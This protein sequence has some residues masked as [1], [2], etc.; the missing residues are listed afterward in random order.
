MHHQPR[1]SRV[2]SAFLAAAL[3]SPLAAQTAPLLGHWEYVSLDSGPRHNPTPVEV[4]VWSDFVIL[5]EGIP[6]L[7]LHFE[8]A[9]LGKGSW[10]R[11]T[12][13]LDGDFM[14]MRQE[15]LEQWAFTSC[16]LNG[17]AVMLELFAG[18]NTQDNR[19]EITKVAAGDPNPAH[20]E[21][22]TICGGTDDRVPSTDARTGRI[23]PV[24]CTG[25]IID[26]PAAGTNKVHLSAGHCVATG[27]VLQ[28][29]VPSS[30]ANCTRQH[31][32]AAK[33]FAID[34]A[35][36]VFVNGG[37]GNDYWVFRC[38]PNSTTGRTTFEEQGAAWTLSPA[39]PALNTPLG[40]FGY[41]L[42]G[43]DT[44]GAP[45]AGSCSCSSSA[46]TGTRNQT[47]QYHFGP[48]IDAPGTSLRYQFDTCGGNS[49]SPVRDNTTGLAVAIH[50]HG[51]CSNPVGTTGNQGTQVTH[52]NLVAAIATVAGT[53]A[54]A[55][56][57]CAGA[58]ALI[59]GTN[60]PFHNLDSTL[61]TV[62]FPCGFNVGNDVWFRFTALFN[63]SHTFDTCTP[64]RTFDTV[65]QLF[66]G[67]CTSL[68][69]IACNDDSCGLGSSITATLAAGTTYYLRCGGYNRS[70]G[71]FDVVVNAPA[72]LIYDAGPL[73]TNPT[74]G[75]GGAPLSALQ[76]GLTVFG[77]SA[78]GTFSVADDFATNGPWTVHGVELLC[79][80]TGATAPSIT[81]VFLEI[82]NGDPA[83]TG[84]PIAG[85]PGFANN[86]VT[87]PGYGVTNTMTGIYRAL[88]SAP[89]GTTRQI[90]SVVVGFPSP[91]VLDSSAIAGGRYWLRWQLAGSV[92][93]G[94]W[95]PPITVLGSLATGSSYQH[96][97]TTYA[98]VVD[99]GNG[100]GLPF[101]LYGT[102]TSLPQLTTN[103]GGGCS[104]AS[105][106]VRG[107]PHVGGVLHLALVNTDPTAIPLVELGVTN[108][109]TP[110][111][112]SCSCVQRTSLEV[113]HVGTAYNWQVPM[114]PAAVGFEFYTQGAQV[115]GPT[116]ACDIGI[117]FRFELTDAYRVRFW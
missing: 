107:A 9:H 60:G 79:Y 58:I 106:E 24:G 20:P 14:T 72:N 67:T 112:P 101:R 96:N 47:Q 71:N 19:I 97:G 31:P 28:F 40:N 66:S 77:Y 50:T 83:T 78:V 57:E 105:L 49:G 10:L 91:L 11:I 43:T 59:A 15:H 86:L 117:G 44:N 63:G 30:L 103:L 94:P 51:G 39:M 99:S 38:F 73:V 23:D 7:R 41:G 6:W 89:T 104:A 36:D 100:Q 80:Q 37:V 82:Y 64:T 76:T 87:T 90:Q 102:S 22:D 116:L 29:A 93:S 81:G 13:V 32:P 54:Q 3:L 114:V 45:A 4:M 12:S 26:Y 109:N 88:E 108:P 53:G 75:S 46:G 27:N 92:A 95:V 98:A 62:A 33:Q 1:P 8:H 111:A 61:S 84:V 115:F 65:L 69:S 113:V 56:D 74:G 25:W 35:T 70:S 68:V 48:L 5:P 42:D 2:L 110:Y 85:S 18:P 34:T 16:Y 55:N 52:P 21:P 17:N